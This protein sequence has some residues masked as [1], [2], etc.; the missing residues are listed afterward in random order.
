MRCGGKTRGAVLGNEVGETKGL[1]R[2]ELVRPYK[3][4]KDFGFYSEMCNYCRVLKRSIMRLKLP[5]SETQES[6][7]SCL[8]SSYHF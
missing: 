2:R 6:S 3:P 5:K 4:L 8:F 1:G 7:D